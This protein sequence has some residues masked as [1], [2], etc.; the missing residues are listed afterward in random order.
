MDLIALC[1]I[2]RNES[3]L[4]F[5][6]MTHPEKFPFDV[7]FSLEF[8]N[9][10]SF[11]IPDVVQW[12]YN[13]NK[14]GFILA[15]IIENNKDMY[16]NWQLSTEE[17][18]QVHKFYPE[19]DQ[20]NLAREIHQRTISAPPWINPVD[21]V[22]YPDVKSWCFWKACLSDHFTV[23][24]L[25]LKHIHHPSS[26]L[27]H[28]MFPLVCKQSAFCMARWIFEIKIQK[29]KIKISF[30]FSACICSPNLDFVQWLYRLQRTIDVY[31]HREIDL[32][33]LLLKD[34]H[35]P[36][37][38]WW[39]M[40]H[41]CLSECLS[42]PQQQQHYIRKIIESKRENVGEILDWL[43]TMGVNI[44]GVNNEHFLFSCIHQR[45]NVVEYFYNHYYNQ[46]LPY[47]LVRQ[48]KKCTFY[49]GPVFVWLEQ[50]VPWGFTTWFK[51]VQSYVST[52][53]SKS[54]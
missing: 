53:F 7:P 10:W 35:L 27:W 47:E 31:Q 40:M 16:V 24:Q 6:R 3:I 33:Y 8:M 19:S 42:D 15:R 37:I 38:Q 2:N 41:P 44:A 17:I 52:L 46:N 26:R 50:K 43:R 54:K 14:L 30:V 25:L 32:F 5:C 51:H 49:E 48:A 4:E 12:W 28:D 9:H 13:Q 34:G 39:Y 21:H 22:L 18:R 1:V 36:V 45:L 29:H 11:H 23:A 20:F